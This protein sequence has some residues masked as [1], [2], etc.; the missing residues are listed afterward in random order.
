MFISVVVTLSET[1]DVPEEL[2]ATVSSPTT[3][4]APM[5]PV[6][7]VT[8]PLRTAAKVPTDDQQA[9]EGTEDE[10]EEVEVREEAT[11]AA[12]QEEEFEDVEVVEVEVEEEVEEE[13][14]EE[15]VVEEEVEVVEEEE[16]EIVAEDNAGNE[17][18][19]AEQKEA[20][21]DDDDFW[22][23]VEE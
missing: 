5:S 4:G 19:V 20:A 3:G 8:L 9:P 12:E 10:Y 21:G 6:E 11:P 23:T 2:E 16:V 17:G 1:V 18:A 15:I 13:E 14:E 7:E 22:A